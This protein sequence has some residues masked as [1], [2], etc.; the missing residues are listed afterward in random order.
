MKVSM[1]MFGTHFCHTNSSWQLC[2]GVCHPLVIPSILDRVNSMITLSLIQNC[3]VVPGA[4]K[5]WGPAR[6]LR[7][8]SQCGRSP[9]ACKIV[10]HFWDR[11]F[12]NRQLLG[13]LGGALCIMTRLSG[14]GLSLL[15]VCLSVYFALYSVITC[16]A[17]LCNLYWCL[18]KFEAT[19]N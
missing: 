7:A 9:N 18:I 1:I 13:P 4:A 5:P 14:L 15:V 17:I 3:N 2:R 11:P 6:H 12:G 19:L 16:V 10:E 8:R